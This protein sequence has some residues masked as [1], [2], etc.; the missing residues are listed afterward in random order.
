MAPD[1]MQLSTYHHYICRL[2]AKNVY[3]KSTQEKI[4]QS[5]NWGIY[6]EVMLGVFVLFVQFFSKFESFQNENFVRI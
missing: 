4:R 5:D 3:P 6:M 1:V 2:L